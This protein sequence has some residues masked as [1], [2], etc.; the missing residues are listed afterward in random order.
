M[1]LKREVGLDGWSRIL[2]EESLKVKDHI[3]QLIRFR[4]KEAS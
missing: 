1:S 3:I 4:N 2:Y